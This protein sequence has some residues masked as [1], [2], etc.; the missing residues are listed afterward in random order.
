VETL[1]EAWT[2]ARLRE[3]WLKEAAV[4]VRKATAPKSIRL[5]W[6]DG[7][8]VAVGFFAKGVSKSSVAIEHTKLPDRAT[9][10]RI[11]REWSDR[12]D[13][14]GDVLVLRDRLGA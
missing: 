11:K 14:L 10:D 13:A 6:P 2:D 9:G 7:G 12:F 8:I 3:R 4:K 1:F 5:G